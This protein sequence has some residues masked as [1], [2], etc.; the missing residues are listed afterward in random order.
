MKRIALASVAALAVVSAANAAWGYA[1]NAHVAICQHVL[2]EIQKNPRM[3]FEKLGVPDLTPTTATVDGNKTA[4]P[5]KGVVY[6][7]PFTG[8][9]RFF[10]P[11]SLSPENARIVLANKAYFRAGCGAPDAFPFFGNTDPS[12]SYAWDPVTQA[13]VILKFATTDA[14]KAFALGYYAHL[15]MD[16]AVHAFANTYA[17]LSMQKHGKLKGTLRPQVWDT[18]EPSNF[19]GHVASESWVNNFYIYAA[20][21]ENYEV[22]VPMELV[23]KLFLTRG[24][25]IVKHYS[26]LL[27][28][29]K[30]GKTGDIKTAF[31]GD[32]PGMFATI[33]HR[34][35][36]HWHHFEDYHFRQWYVWEGHAAYYK[37]KS[38]LDDK[39]H[40]WV[41]YLAADWHKR[42]Y[43]KIRRIYD[44]WAATT[45]AL[46]TAVSARNMK[47]VL[48]AFKPFKDA[49]V[50]YLSL[51]LVDV[52][53]FLP[54]ALLAMYDA[55][56]SVFTA[57]SDAVK[58]VVTEVLKTIFK[59]VIEKIEEL[60]N[61]AIGKF[62]DRY[63]DR[64]ARDHA[65]ALLREAGLVGNP[66][67]SEPEPSGAQKPKATNAGIDGA[68]NPK[69][70]EANRKK[71]LKYPF[72]RNAFMNVLA[73][74][75]DPN[76]LRDLPSADFTNS[77]RCAK[78]FVNS[79]KGERQYLSIMKGSD[80]LYNATAEV[81]HTPSYTRLTD[82]TFTQY[83]YDKQYADL[84]KPS[85]YSI[86]ATIASMFRA[87]GGTIAD[88]GEW[89][90]GKLSGF[91]NDLTS[92]VTKDLVTG[93]ENARKKVAELVKSATTAV[94]GAAKK[95][96]DWA[97]YNL[98]NAGCTADWV[99]YVTC[100][101][102]TSKCRE[103]RTACYRGCDARYKK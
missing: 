81:C 12:H 11:F 64:K 24:S 97:G 15:A 27:A 16:A 8:Q 51:D 52:R 76:N 43:E 89:L 86:R 56:K 69:A 53:K 47:N 19:L 103:G 83:D 65:R 7:K 17:G 87:L 58:K 85:P 74:L 29:W 6:G 26:R 39:L 72:Y 67:E 28:E 10:T 60:A 73:V 20:R 37:G 23:K 79:R 33:M 49:I 30:P 80:P 75:A 2:D 59:D 102:G 101:R 100:F 13:E 48:G 32:K 34:A 96:V 40:Y 9:E 3:V 44:A 95:V 25:P 14:E 70:N 99:P 68:G 21:P 45:V 77:W 38:S 42:R 22:K 94:E 46:Q 50:A 61:V 63:M 4:D 91:V 1:L 31:Y 62:L 82:M 54:K 92:K 41:A 35:L 18:F 88:A 78:G 90:W 57:I 93:Y 36:S 5:T 66:S 71:L 55:V 84:R 98:C